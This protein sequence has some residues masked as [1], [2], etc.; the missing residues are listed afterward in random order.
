MSDLV[1]HYLGI[2]PGIGEGARVSVEVEAAIAPGDPTGA[3]YGEG[4]DGPG[5]VSRAGDSG[6]QSRC[7]GIGAAMARAATAAGAGR[8]SLSRAV[9]ERLLGDCEHEQ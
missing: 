6:A 2:R 8:A 7:N 3:S 1:A 5:C 4:V 9:G